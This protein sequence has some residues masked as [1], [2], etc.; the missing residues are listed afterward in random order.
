MVLNPSPPPLLVSEHKYDTSVSWKRRRDAHEGGV[1]GAGGQWRAAQYHFGKCIP[2]KIADTFFS[3]LA[4]CRS[5][6][7]C[8]D[9]FPNWH[10]ASL[11]LFHETA[12]SYLCSET[13][14]Q[15]NLRTKCVFRHERILAFGISFMKRILQINIRSRRNTHVVA[16]KH[17]YCF[18]ICHKKRYKTPI[19]ARFGTHI[20]FSTLSALVLQHTFCLERDAKSVQ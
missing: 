9:V 12:V 20:L 5:V 1:E 4:F 2:T 16:S 10:F 13:S 7:R 11:H 17:I 19:F 6:C 15:T 8:G 14:A 18:Q 3:G